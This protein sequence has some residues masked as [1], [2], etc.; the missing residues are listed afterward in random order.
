VCLGTLGEF[1]VFEE[2][3]QDF[4]VGCSGVR[5]SACVIRVVRCNVG[6]LA[7][8][9][10]WV[11][12]LRHSNLHRMNG[13]SLEEIRERQHSRVGC[14]HALPPV[15]A[16]EIAS[17]DQLIA[18]PS[19][20]LASVASGRLRTLVLVLGYCGLRFGEAAALRVRDVDTD[21]RRIRY[22]GQ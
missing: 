6:G 21:N 13:K 20:F 14:P 7:P 11:P 16:N 5:R 3:L 22:G 4:K 15:L 12:E 10:V 1:G 19:R 2:V 17:Q 18:R 9:A 8:D